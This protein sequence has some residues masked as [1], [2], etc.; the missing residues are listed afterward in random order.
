[1]GAL[2]ADEMGGPILQRGAALMQ[3]LIEKAQK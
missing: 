1:M 3:A 2:S